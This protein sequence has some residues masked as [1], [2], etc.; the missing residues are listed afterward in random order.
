MLPEAL[1]V[2]CKGSRALKSDG[3]KFQSFLNLFETQ[4]LSVE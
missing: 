4:F 2:L 3:L 1:A